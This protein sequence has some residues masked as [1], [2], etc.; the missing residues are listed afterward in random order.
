MTP[1]NSKGINMNGLPRLIVGAMFMLVT[2]GCQTDQEVQIP[3]NPAPPPTASP[4]PIAE[5]TDS[6]DP[7]LSRKARGR[8]ARA[9]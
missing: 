5:L 6:A 1:H 2:M 3:E 8:D 9:E 4:R 7:S